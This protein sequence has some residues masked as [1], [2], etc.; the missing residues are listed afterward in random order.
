MARPPITYAQSLRTRF[1]YAIIKSNCSLSDAQKDLEFCNPDLEERAYE[2]RRRIFNRM[3]KGQMPYRDA[4]RDAFITSVASYDG[5]EFTAKV[6]YSEF[7]SLI[8]QPF[9]GEKNN[10]LILKCFHKLCITSGKVPSS[11]VISEDVLIKESLDFDPFESTEPNLFKSKPADLIHYENTLQ[12]LLSDYPFN[13]DFVTLIA[14]LFR[15]ALDRGEVEVARILRRNYLSQLEHICSYYQVDQSLRKEL[16]TISEDNILK[17]NTS[18]YSS[19]MERLLVISKS[20]NHP[21]D[22]L[23]DFFLMLHEEI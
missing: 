2:E 8:D 1:Y 20:I 7:W 15:N 21:K 4:T 10:L 9:I 3:K 19:Y 23:L 11:T 5:L 17:L 13:L 12:N 18:I 6:Y 22:E 14:A 16:I